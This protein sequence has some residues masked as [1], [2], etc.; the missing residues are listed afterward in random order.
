MCFSDTIKL[1]T[2]ISIFYKTFANY[3]IITPFRQICLVVV[4]L[5][6][7]DCQMYCYKLMLGDLCCYGKLGSI[8]WW[9]FTDVSGRHLWTLWPLK[10]EPIGFYRN[11][12]K[13]LHIY[14]AYYPRRAKIWFPP[15]WKPWII[16]NAKESQLVPK[17]VVSTGLVC[18]AVRRGVLGISSSSRNTQVLTNLSRNPRDVEI[19]P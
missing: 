17:I 10:T 2:Y 9:L 4:V 15:G 7:F 5:W 19:N 1:K 13:Y 3:F 12:D 14:T 18:S 11:V 16:L 8:Y 6:L